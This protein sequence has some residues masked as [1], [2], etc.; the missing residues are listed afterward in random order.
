MVFLLTHFINCL[1]SQSCRSI[2]PF[3][4]LFYPCLRF[5]K[6]NVFGSQQMHHMFFTHEIISSLKLRLSKSFNVQKV[7]IKHLQWIRFY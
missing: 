2:D 3:Q 4:M 7:K 5:S 1:L 6:Q